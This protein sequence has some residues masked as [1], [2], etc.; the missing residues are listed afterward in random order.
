MMEEHVEGNV[1]DILGNLD[2]GI[3][4]GSNEERAHVIKS[5]TPP[6]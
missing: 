5:E 4:R 2:C 1:F 6:S 3:V